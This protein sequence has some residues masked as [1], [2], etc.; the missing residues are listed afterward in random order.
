VLIARSGRAAP[1]PQ[2]DPDASS[3]P[4]IA[5]LIAARNERAALPASLSALRSQSLQPREVLV[6]D[7]GSTDGSVAALSSEWALEF[8]GDL[9]TSRAWPQLRVL[10]KAHSG[11]ARSLNEG[12]RR[13]QST[14]VITL[15]A[16]TLLE[17]GAVAAVA[18]AFAR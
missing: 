5:V 10:R 12:L 3:I 13:V 17:P 1:G 16:D 6:V 18:R 2:A 15:D 11:K 8:A 14:V 9:G 4:A 7:D